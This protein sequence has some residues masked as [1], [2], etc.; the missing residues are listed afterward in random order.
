LDISSEIGEEEIGE[1]KGKR[2]RGEGNRGKGR[3][4]GELDKDV[5]GDVG[6]VGRRRRA[7]EQQG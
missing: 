4:R 6:E 2:E 7:G 1:R 5:E 3:E